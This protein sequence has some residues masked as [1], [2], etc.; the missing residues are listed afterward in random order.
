MTPA[1]AT[2]LFAGVCGASGVGKDTILSGAMAALAARR[3]IVFVRRTI[4]RPADAGGEDHDA[5][6]P[7]RFAELEREGAFCLSWRAH[8]LSYGVPASTINDLAAG[9][10]V[11]CNISRTVA[12]LASDKFPRFALLEITAEP[13]IVTERLAARGRE[14]AGEIAL[15]QSRKIA[16]WHSGVSV[17]QVANNGEPQDAVDRFVS[18]LLSLS[19]QS[20]RQA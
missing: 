3:D 10:T 8:G 6:A 4:T 20:A 11:V 17:Q 7:Q 18:L 15:R 5:V 1:S 13:G 12:V 14:T 16:G 9:R 19:G 2:G